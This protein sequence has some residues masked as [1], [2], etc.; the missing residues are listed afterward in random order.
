MSVKLPNLGSGRTTCKVLIHRHN[1]ENL[2]SKYQGNKDSE[3]DISSYVNRVAVATNIA[4]GGSVSMGL[5][6]AFPWED[7][8]AANDLVNI[9]I[10]TNRG[11]ESGVYEPGDNTWRYNRGNVR[12]F[13]GYVDSITKSISMGGV[14]TRVTSYT[15]ECA[16]FD[17]AIRA[18]TIYSNPHLSYQGDGTPDSVRP[19]ISNNLG[20]MILIQK[21]FPIAGSPRHL[22]IGHLFRTLGFGGQWL[23]PEKYE[24][25]LGKYDDV[26]SSGGGWIT[27]AGSEASFAIDSNVKSDFTPWRLNW[28]TEKRTKHQIEKLGRTPYF[29]KPSIS[30]Y[31]KGDPVIYNTSFRYYPK[32]NQKVGK[33]SSGKIDFQ[34]ALSLVGGFT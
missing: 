11:D 27:A 25:D 5:I 12:V 14:G 24:D 20:G 13:F 31:T 10:N 6:A 16:S 30:Q 19:D 17:K 29:Y 1:R 22:I 15:M 33:A 26:A 23:L 28:E 21:G 3:L 8:I 34:N 2:G 32:T 9:Y 4:G 18:T 7:E